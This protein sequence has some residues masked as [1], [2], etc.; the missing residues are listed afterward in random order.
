MAR[1]RAYLFVVIASAAVKISFEMPPASSMMTSTYW[2]WTPWNPDSSLSSGFM[3]NAMGSWRSP[4][5]HVASA[6]T[7]PPTPASALT[8]GISFHRTLRTCF[9]FVAVVTT[10]VSSTG[11]VSTHQ[12]TRVADKRLLW[13]G[14]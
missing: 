13:V 5:F 10:V 7:L 3:P 1:M 4:I 2:S 9:Q 6:F 11:C 12:L 8:R 14:M